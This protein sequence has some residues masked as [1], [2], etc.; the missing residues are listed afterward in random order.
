MT[1]VKIYRFIIAS[2]VIA[3][4]SCSGSVEKREV[5]KD[6]S[7]KQSLEK[8]NR[9]LVRTESEDIDNYVKRHGWKMEETGTGLR[10]WIYEQGTGK[11][12]E[13]GEIATLNYQTFLIN[14]DLI[15][16]S[17]ELGSK[18]FKIGKGGV[19]SGLEEAILLM[20]V[21]DKAKLVIPSHLAF[22]LLG[23]SDKIPAR[24]TVVYDIE[25]VSLK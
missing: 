24:A 12:A 2:F 13:K 7:S 14:G 9:Y 4:Y 11:Q 1:R 19:E 8:V 10:Y 25:L 18:S 21:G 20:H 23:D 15:Y 3:L 16:S 6:I 17:D 22:G 5:K